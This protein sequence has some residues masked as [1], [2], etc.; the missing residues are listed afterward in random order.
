MLAAMKAKAAE[1]GVELV[2]FDSQQDAAKQLNDVQD[3]VNALKVDAIILNPVDSAS[4]A[5]A[6]DA[7]DAKDSRIH[8]RRCGGRRRGCIAYRFK[9]R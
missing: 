5:P 7:N 3:M 8:G 6:I 9:Q 4:I 1:L 2:D